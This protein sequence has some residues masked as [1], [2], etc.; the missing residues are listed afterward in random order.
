[1][2]GNIS[3]LPIIAVV[4]H[5]SSGRCG[6]VLT[7]LLIKQA[8]GDLA[9]GSLMGRGSYLTRLEDGEDD[10]FSSLCERLYGCSDFLWLSVFFP[11]LLS[12]VVHRIRK[13]T[14]E[15]ATRSVCAVFSYR[16]GIPLDA[17]PVFTIQSQKAEE[18]IIS[19]ASWGG[20]A[21]T[22]LEDGA[23]GSCLSLFERLYGCSD[24][25]WL[26]VLLPSLLWAVILRIL[27]KAWLTLN[28]AT[29]SLSLIPI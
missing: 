23:D 18:E 17:H 19:S 21:L 28:L 22:R 3:G 26:L 10:S 2:E 4:E 11:S 15:D 5:K 14:L 8:E 7:L 1:M 20:S 24:F 13:A 12:A 16:A 6:S 29:S 25:L 9:T 27:R